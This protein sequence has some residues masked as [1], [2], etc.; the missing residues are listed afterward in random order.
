MSGSGMSSKSGP[1]V[2]LIPAAG[3]ATRLVGAEGVVGSKE[4]LPLWLDQDGRPRPLLSYL[5]ERMAAA[6]VDRAIV[7][8]REGKEDIAATLGT[9]RDGVALDFV[10]TPPTPGVPSTLAVADARLRELAR[11]GETYPTILLGFPDILL[12]PATSYAEVMARF[13]E[14]GADLV[15]GLY[16]CDRPDKSDMVVLDD[17]GRVIDLVIKQPDRGLR[18]TWAPAVWS[19]SFQRLL[20]EAA[21]SGER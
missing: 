7:V 2:G 14:S 16:P 15:L 1:A 18:F 13:E 4:V 21:K 5:L 17:E 3:R 8:V 10:V 6:G 20:N 19:T 11:D 9:R 12:W